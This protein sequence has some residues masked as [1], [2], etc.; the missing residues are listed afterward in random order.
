M[1]ILLTN[2]HSARNAGDAILLEQS[3]S[4]L[5]RQFPNA[6]ITVILND[7][8]SFTG[9]EK[10]LPAFATFFK[11]Y[12][13]ES[14]GWRTRC[15]LL[16][17][18]WLLGMVI[19]VTSKR[20]LPV[21][22]VHRRH[23][24]AYF[25]ADLIA[26]VG[27]N[28]FY[29]SG[30]IGLPFLFIFAQLALAILLKKPLV[31]LP[32]TIG[33]LHG[34]RD[35]ALLRWLTEHACAVFLRDAASKQYVGRKHDHVHVVPDLAFADVA[36]DH[37]AAQKVFDEYGIAPSL[38]SPLIGITTLNWGALNPRFVGQSAY[39]K[40]VAE[41]VRHVVTDHAAKVLLLSQVQGPTPDE[42]DRR[43]AGR[44]FERVRDLGER[45]VFVE[46]GC[47][48]ETLQSIYCKLD[49]LVGT[50]LHSNIFALTSRTPVMAIAYQPKTLGV[51]KMLQLEEWVMP[52][53]T[54]TGE[55]LIE[56]FD[57]LW[58][59]LPAIQEQVNT[60]MDM[61]AQ[62]VQQTGALLKS[63]VENCFSNR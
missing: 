1:K 51:L 24:Q 48:A 33:P 40:A 7:P 31:L 28:Y 61:L 44:I 27:G 3:L 15:L 59:Q 4:L 23:L 63:H 16:L 56:R 45:V 60:E 29:S 52:I 14:A 54:V 47:S 17:P 30:K 41:L 6:E 32:Q 49:L 22:A 53:D 5:Y 18:V 21:P 43:T 8:A 26:S 9:D 11:R 38:D 12:D 50:R 25:S 10:T 37:D 39:E 62:R 20:I 46:R 42:D 2:V 35:R 19:A 55:Q 58:Q 57:I 13:A 34:K 36:A